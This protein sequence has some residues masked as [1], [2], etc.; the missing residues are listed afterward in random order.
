MQVT[1]PVHLTP[2]NGLRSLLRASTGDF[3][4]VFSWLL[5][6]YTPDLKH[7][8][9]SGQQKEAF[10]NLSLGCTCWQLHEA[11]LCTRSA[12]PRTQVTS[13]RRARSDPGRRSRPTAPI[14]SSVN[15][16]CRRVVYQITWYT[17][18]DEENRSRIGPAKIFSIP[19]TTT[20][21]LGATLP[22]KARPSA[23]LRR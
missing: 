7:V 14:Y 13:A 10:Y 19:C 20:E 18:R 16:T 17:A 21:L 12:F 4:N 3:Q 9:Y 2:A 23:R 5:L 1:R 11:S 8:G 15:L 6:C 22:F